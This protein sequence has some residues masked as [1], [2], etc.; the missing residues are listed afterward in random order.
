MIHPKVNYQGSLHLSLAQDS[1]VTTYHLLDGENMQEDVFVKLTAA[2]AQCRNYGLYK[3]SAQ[4]NLNFNIIVDHLVT[5]CKSKILY[6]GMAD[7]Q[8]RVHFVGKIIVHERAA[9]SEAR[10]DNKNLLLQ[11]TARIVS[12]P[13]LEI[14]NDD[15]HCSHG[16]TVGQLDATALWYLQSRGI[17]H[18]EAR[19]ILMQ[20]FLQEVL[21]I[22]PICLQEK[23][24]Q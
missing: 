24:L 17:V 22:L 4:Q 13:A 8:A 2:Q 10:L 21:Q 11:D 20:A 18:E 14:Y 23:Y 7:E 15:V 6:K 1:N 19:T 3:L 9:R 12:S 5:D 16:A